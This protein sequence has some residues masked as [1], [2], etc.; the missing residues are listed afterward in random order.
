MLEVRDLR[1]NPYL[2]VE[3]KVIF[4]YLKEIGDAGFVVY[5]YLC[6]RADEHDRCFPSIGRMASDLGKSTTTVQGA[7]K[8]LYA[9]GLVRHE[10]RREGS[11]NKANVY[12]LLDAPESPHMSNPDMSDRD[13]S[14]SDMERESSLKRE[15]SLNDIPPSASLPATQ[16]SKSKIPKELVPWHKSLMGTLANVCYSKGLNGLTRAETGK[17]AGA[18]RALLEVEA[19]EDDVIERAAVYRKKYGDRVELTPQALASNWSKL[20]PKAKPI[21]VLV[22]PPEAEPVSVLT[23]EEAAE[24]SRMA[25]ERAKR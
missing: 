5:A 6:A 18:A 24:M 20:V 9:C 10:K 14:K 7:L 19:T 15:S 12:V 16:G 13:M 17:L 11:R 8:R 4:N 2:R 23:A 3:K 22:Q 21:I 1:S 25:K